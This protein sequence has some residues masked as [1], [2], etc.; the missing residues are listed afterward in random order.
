MLIPDKKIVKKI[1]EKFLKKESESYLTGDRFYL[2]YIAD[3][4]KWKI[5][6][7]PVITGKKNFLNKMKRNEFE[8]SPLIKIKNIIAAGEYVVIESVG[9]ASSKTGKHFK[10]AYCDIY[11]IKNGKIQEMTTYFID[12]H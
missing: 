10:H 5:I 9:K 1:T 6:G 11:K 4:I 7:Q 8:N 2:E 12:I 3:D